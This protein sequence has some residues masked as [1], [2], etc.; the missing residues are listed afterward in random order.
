MKKELDGLRKQHAPCPDLIQS[1]KSELE[2]VKAA[3]APC[4]AQIAELKAHLKR[5]DKKL[6]EE[7]EKEE[8]LAKELA[9]EKRKEEE[10]EKNL[11]KT[12]AELEKDEK[13]LAEDK[14]VFASKD[15]EIAD[16][17]KRLAELQKQ[18]EPCAGTL[19]VHM[20]E[21]A[22]D[23]ESRMLCPTTCVNA[24]LHVSARWIDEGLMCVVEQ[25]SSKPGTAPSHSATKRSLSFNESLTPPGPPTR[26]VKLRSRSSR[27]TWLGWTRSWQRSWRRR[28]PL[29][30]SSPRRSARRRSWTRT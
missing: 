5:L 17:K 1:L 14:K 13:N 10:L 21:D 26:R 27:R 28:R 18:H 19:L 12:K 3:H 20:K 25:A 6:A 2:A 7:L 11:K 23:G 24:R 30:R 15:A 4:D 16:L 8:K 29:R 9:E 22:L